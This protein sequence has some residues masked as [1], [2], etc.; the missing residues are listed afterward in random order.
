MLK[1]LC[2]FLRTTAFLHATNLLSAKGVLLVSKKKKRFV[3]D[4]F[5]LDLTYITPVR[6]KIARTFLGARAV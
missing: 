1:T 2:S 3:E 6:R 5:D 4:G